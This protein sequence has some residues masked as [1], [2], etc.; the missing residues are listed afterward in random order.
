LVQ[1]NQPFLDVI[2]PL[3]CRSVDAPQV[4][5]D[6]AEHHHDIA[7][8]TMIGSQPLSGLSPRS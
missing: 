7:P 2:G 4:L 3:A 8:T 6:H 5:S 1:L